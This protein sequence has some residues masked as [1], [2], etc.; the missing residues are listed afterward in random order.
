M[1]VVQRRDGQPVS[2]EQK[3]FVKFGCDPA[4]ALGPQAAAL[5]SDHGY[6]RLVFP[7]LEAA[8]FFPAVD[9]D[10]V[11][12]LVARQHAQDDDPSASRGNI[13]IPDREA[14]GVELG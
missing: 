3:D 9:S 8:L 12:L 4:T 2:G 6:L 7:D 11:F 5:A 14:L 1:H 13:L 10:A